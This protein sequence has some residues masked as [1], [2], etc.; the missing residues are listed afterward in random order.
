VK[1]PCLIEINPGLAIFAPG[2]EH[3]NE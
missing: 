2:L 3:N 1:Q